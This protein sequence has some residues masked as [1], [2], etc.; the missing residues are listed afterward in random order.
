M[1]GEDLRETGGNEETN[2]RPYSL[3]HP[4]ASPAVFRFRDVL[5]RPPCGGRAGAKEEQD[6][7]SRRKP[8]EEGSL[9]EARRQSFGLALGDGGLRPQ[10]RLSSKGRSLER[11]RGWRPDESG[12]VTGGLQTAGYVAGNIACC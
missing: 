10:V 12:C 3:G 6:V 9:L 7:L 4:P 11:A 2:R 5:R 1:G 8:K